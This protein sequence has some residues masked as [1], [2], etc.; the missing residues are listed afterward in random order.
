SETAFRREEYKVLRNAR[1]ESELLIRPNAVGNYKNIVSE[2]FSTV[3]SIN[4]LRETRALAG[5]S[6]IFPENDGG[7]ERRKTMLRRRPPPTSQC[8]LPAYTVFGEGIFLEFD[9][10]RL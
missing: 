4:K 10:R 3:N 7:I 5:F 2:Y 9:H 1:D 8:W 6:R